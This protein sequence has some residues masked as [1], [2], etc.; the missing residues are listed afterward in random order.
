MLQVKTFGTISATLNEFGIGKHL[1]CH[2]YTLYIKTLGFTF[3]CSELI[4]EDLNV[5]RGMEN[6]VSRN[7]F[8]Y[9]RNIFASFLPKLSYF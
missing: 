5:G 3:V 2:I 1:V 8:K 6:T 9:V 4:E 7:K